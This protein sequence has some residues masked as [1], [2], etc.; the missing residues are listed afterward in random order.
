MDWDNIRGI[1]VKKRDTVK[2]KKLTDLYV[3]YIINKKLDKYHKKYSIKNN[4]Y[5][6]WKII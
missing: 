5:V 3:T 4:K 1:N 2:N 6:Q